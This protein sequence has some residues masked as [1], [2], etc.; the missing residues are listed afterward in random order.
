MEYS[1]QMVFCEIRGVARAVC[2]AFTKS[3]DTFGGQGGS[4]PCGVEGQSIPLAAEEFF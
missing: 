4:V 2:E 3:A 1:L